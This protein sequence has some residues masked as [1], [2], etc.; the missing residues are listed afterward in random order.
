MRSAGQT[1]QS[2]TVDLLPEFILRAR[3]KP[4][5]ARVGAGRHQGQGPGGLR[6]KSRAVQDGQVLGRRSPGR[7]CRTSEWGRPHCPP[8]PR[9]PRFLTAPGH[10][11]VN[12]SKILPSHQPHPPPAPLAPRNLINPSGAPTLGSPMCLGPPLHHGVGVGRCGWGLLAEASPQPTTLT[13]LFSSMHLS[14]KKESH[15]P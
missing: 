8:G 9:V 1:G 13:Y 7:E 5:G 2:W 12:P 15:G 11:G 10:R 4:E 14:A 3:R 6:G